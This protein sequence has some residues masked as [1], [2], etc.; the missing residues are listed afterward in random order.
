MISQNSQTHKFHLNSRFMHF[1]P[2]KLHH[3]THPLV[4]RRSPSRALL[5]AAEGAVV[6]DDAEMS[7]RGNQ[8]AELMSSV[9]STTHKGQIWEKTMDFI[10]IPYRISIYIYKST[11]LCLIIQGMNLW[12]VIYRGL[13]VN[14]YLA[15]EYYRMFIYAMQGNVLKKV[16]RIFIKEIE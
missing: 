7:P 3:F 13:F 14:I 6:L 15:I 4:P 8:H 9:R 12:I 1:L 5:R 10:G 11:V 16:K 2:R